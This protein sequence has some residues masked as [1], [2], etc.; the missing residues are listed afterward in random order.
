MS[1]A[2]AFAAGL[3]SFLSP[4]ILPLVLPYLCFLTG[5]DLSALTSADKQ[6]SGQ[7]FGRAI[8]FVAGFAAVFVL[9]GATASTLGQWL[10]RWY[11]ALSII[12]GA[13]ILILGL[14][15]LGVFRVML[16]FRE[17]RFS[18]RA[19]ASNAGAFIVGLA[20]AFG[21]TPCVGPVLA[22]ILIVAA[23]QDTAVQGMA[24]LGAYAMGIGVPFL[25]ASLFVSPFA[26][27]LSKFRSHISVVEK[28]IGAVM[29]ATGLL[30]I[31]GLMPS[32]GNWL[33]ETFPSLGKVG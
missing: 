14:H 21:W 8:F 32:V 20:F 6:R 25:V 12:A 19:P 16:F 33:L 30:F 11:D 26:A 3:L 4:C 2:G 18:A 10:T 28:I 31:T 5:S 23:A 29:V 22:S 24:L 7:S 15:F 13:L 9:L 17:L 27:F 1:F